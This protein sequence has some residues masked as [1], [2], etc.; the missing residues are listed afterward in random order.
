MARG[1]KIS[2]QTVKYQKALGR[3]TVSTLFSCAS[4]RNAVLLQRKTE[5]GMKRKTFG[6]LVAVLALALAGGTGWSLRDLPQKRLLRTAENIVFAD[7]DSTERLLEQVDTTRLTESSRMLYDLLR[8]LVYEERWYLLRADTASCLSSDAEAWTFARQSDDQNKDGQ[9]VPDDSCR[10]R[11]Y[12][13]Y[14]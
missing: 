2:L 8:A 12:H 10:L 7:A 13:Y 4:R 11:I 3:R 1:W 6:I 9:A 14:E 5:K